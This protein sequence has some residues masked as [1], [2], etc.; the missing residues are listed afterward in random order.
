MSMHAP[1]VVAKPFTDLPLT[2][3][4]R[5][6]AAKADHGDRLGQVRIFLRP[7]EKLAPFMAGGR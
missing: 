1:N 6:N 3:S 5:T 7:V 4:P 2:D